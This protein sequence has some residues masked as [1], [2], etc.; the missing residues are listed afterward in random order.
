MPDLRFTRPGIGAGIILAIAAPP[1]FAQERTGWGT[2]VDG[3]IVQQGDTDLDSGGSFNATRSFVRAGTVYRLDNGNSFGISASIGQLNY[4]FDG[5][6]DQPWEDIRDVRLSLPMR[7]GVGTNASA[8][9]APQVRWDYQSGASASDGVTYG[10]FA[11]IAWQVNQ[12]LRIGPAFGA[13][14]QLEGDVDVFPALLVDWDIADRWNLSTGTGPGA[15]RGPG[16]SLSYQ[17]NEAF[18]VG[19]S[20]RSEKIRFRLDDDGLAP[21]GVGEDSSLPIAFSVSYEPNPGL[22]VTGFVGAEFGGELTL[23]DT[24]GNELR[25][26]SYDT[27]PIAGVAFRLRF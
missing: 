7:F 21:G 13:Y 12:S 17:I 3:L 27:A 18:S 19:L 10:V 11:G 26:E 1:A 9:I 8:F 14:S 23:D 22:S 24:N 25:S 5:V 2:Q 15:T 16:L 4:D 20:A 6:V